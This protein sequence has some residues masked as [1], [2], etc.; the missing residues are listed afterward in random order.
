M[1]A[2]PGIEECSFPE[3]NKDT[4]GHI[5]SINLIRGNM[6][7]ML[8]QGRRQF[9]AIIVAPIML[10]PLKYSRNREVATKRRCPLKQHTF[11]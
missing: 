11:R 8:L 3:G 10:Q 6:G 7:S 2:G 4:K 5:G 1:G 9:A